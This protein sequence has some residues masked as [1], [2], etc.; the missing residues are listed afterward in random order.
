MVESV[1][2]KDLKSFG[3]WWLCG[4][5]SRSR[6]W[7]GKLKSTQACLNV[8]LGFCFCK[9]RKGLT[10]KVPLAVLKEKAESHWVIQMGFCFF[11]QCVV[12]FGVAGLYLRTPPCCRNS[13]ESTFAKCRVNADHVLAWSGRGGHSTQPKHHKNR[14]KVNFLLFFLCLCVFF[15]T[16]APKLAKTNFY[17]LHFSV[18]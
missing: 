6:Y 18:P 11:R 14:I 13:P 10:Q 5:K 9:W 16:F 15:C 2:T 1:D 17:V 7:K 12:C 4:F 3:Q 8:F